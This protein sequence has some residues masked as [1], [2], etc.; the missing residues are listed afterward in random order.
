MKHLCISTTV[1]AYADYSKPFKLHNDTCGQG[2]G[3]VLYQT[4]EGGLDRVIAYA[5]QTLSKSKRNYPAHKLEF[6]ALKWVI[7]DQ[8]H[9]YLYVG[10]LDVYTDNKPL[11]YIL[12]W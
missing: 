8:F 5:S 2:L 11:T 9:E 3:A 12:H 6:L 1:L 10:N 7:M 4:S